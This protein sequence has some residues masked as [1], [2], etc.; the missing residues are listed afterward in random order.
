MIGDEWLAVAEMVLS[1]EQPD[2]LPAYLPAFVSVPTYS[3]EQSAAAHAL[4]RSI[5]SEMVALALEVE[6]Q[7]IS[8]SPVGISIPLEYR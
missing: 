1:P 2:L 7:A 3:E 5:V 8:I 6:W 4:R